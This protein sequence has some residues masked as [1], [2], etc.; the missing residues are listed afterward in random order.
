MPKLKRAIA[1][2]IICLRPHVFLALCILLVIFQS[3][4]VS[5]QKSSLSYLRVS[6][7]PDI[8]LTMVALLL[9]ALAWMAFFIVMIKFELNN[10]LDTMLVLFQCSKRGLRFLGVVAFHVGLL[11]IVALLVSM[12]VNR[13]LPEDTSNN[14]EK[15]VADSYKHKSSDID[16]KVNHRPGSYSIIHDYDRQNRDNQHKLARISHGSP[17]LDISLA[18][19][20]YYKTDY[21]SKDRSDR[22]R[23]KMDRGHLLIVYKIWLTAIVYA[24]LYLTIENLVLFYVD[25]PLIECVHEVFLNLVAKLTG[26]DLSDCP[27]GEM[28]FNP[29]IR[30]LFH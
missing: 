16:P 3:I 28:L 22:F 21:S 25:M 17:N 24:F 8:S 30:R 13:S 14:L 6:R 29:L 5:L 19:Y 15:N 26:V 23:G 18:S 27:A 4:V 12:S 10:Q 1:A 11:L 7:Q 20:R 9:V 2:V